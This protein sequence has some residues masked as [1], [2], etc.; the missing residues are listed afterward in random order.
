M[1]RNSAFGLLVLCKV[2]HGKDEKIGHFTEGHQCLSQNE[3]YLWF[4]CFA[5]GSGVEEEG[6]SFLKRQQRTE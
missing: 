2:L 1:T 5:R 3:S 6:M 4:K